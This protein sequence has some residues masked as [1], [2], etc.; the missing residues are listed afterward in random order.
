[1]IKELRKVFEK[2]PT[3]GKSI[4]TEMLRLFR[5]DT[6]RV[7]QQRSSGDYGVLH[8]G[9]LTSEDLR[10][11]ILGNVSVSIYLLDENSQCSTICF[12]VDIP[13]IKI[14][15]NDD[16]RQEKKKSEFLPVIIRIID[17]IK[18]I[19]NVSDD[20]FLLEDTGGRGYHL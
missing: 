1:M 11:H 6:R 16:E 14:P 19:Y 13:K 20:L 7:M 5:G 15:E 2:D 12:D 4:I 10:R 8:S 3:I 18:S 9:S 17:H